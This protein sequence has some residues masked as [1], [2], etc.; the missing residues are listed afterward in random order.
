MTSIGWLVR[1]RS[2]NMGAVGVWRPMCPSFLFL[3]A[4]SQQ[5]EVRSSW[6]PA[7]V[8]GSPPASKSIL[9]G[10]ASRSPAILSIFA[11]SR[12]THMR[13]RVKGSLATN[14]FESLQLWASTLPIFSL[15][16]ST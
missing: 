12:Q 8:S 4:D 14:R 10:Q 13:I 15:L 11:A 9:A 5:C 3:P 1:R 7:R 6:A 2:R 16:G